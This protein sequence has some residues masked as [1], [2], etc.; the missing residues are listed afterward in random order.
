MS[1][2]LDFAKLFC[3]VNNKIHTSSPYIVA[4]ASTYKEITSHKKTSC[5]H[6][7]T[8]G[9]H[10]PIFPLLRTFSCT[11]PLTIF[12]CTF[13][14]DH[15]PLSVWAINCQ[16]RKSFINVAQKMASL[17]QQLLTCCTLKRRCERQS[18]R[19][20]SYFETS[21]P[22]NFELKFFAWK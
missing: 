4:K 2:S 8:R 13:R 18:M 16:S 1:R 6:I 14:H 3:V 7:L 19:K 20:K 9:E 11:F 17:L 12:I 22:P 21:K 5:H 15:P 10:L